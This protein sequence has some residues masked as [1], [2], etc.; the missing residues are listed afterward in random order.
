MLFSLSKIP[1]MAQVQ[2]TKCK[3]SGTF[4]EIGL[5]SFNDTKLIMSGQGRAF[6]TNGKNSTKEQKYSVIMELTNHHP[7]TT[8]LMSLVYHY[9]WANIQATLALEQLRRIDE[10]ILYKKWLF[11]E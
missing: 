3:Q 11:H 1:R 2:P 9:N 8:G 4:G 6:C 10:L 7:S 5:F